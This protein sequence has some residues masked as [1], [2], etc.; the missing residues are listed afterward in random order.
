MTCLLAIYLNLLVSYSSSESRKSFISAVLSLACAL[1]IGIGRFRNRSS[2]NFSNDQLCLQTAQS[3]FVQAWFCPMS[4]LLQE[5]THP[6]CFNARRRLNLLWTDIPPVKQQLGGVNPDKNHAEERSSSALSGCQGDC[7]TP[8]A[9]FCI[10]GW[11][12]MV[13]KLH[14]S[15]DNSLLLTKREEPALHCLQSPSTRSLTTVYAG[16]GIPIT[17]CWFT[18]P[19]RQEKAASSCQVSEGELVQPN[20]IYLSEREFCN[21]LKLPWS[22]TEKK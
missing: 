10:W 14:G 4:K 19:W 7:V 13:G 11:N 9:E 3:P 21:W 18:L 12:Y 2:V 22:K 16:A 15:W 8:G 1:K 20:L 5:P 17:L 6:V